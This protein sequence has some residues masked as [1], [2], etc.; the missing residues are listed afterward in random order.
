MTSVLDL[1]KVNS[2]ISDLRG[3]LHAMDTRLVRVV[4]RIES[5]A[6][7]FVSAEEAS[8]TACSSEAVPLCNC[9]GVLGRVNWAISLAPIL[10][11]CPG[12]GACCQAFRSEFSRQFPELT[13]PH[14]TSVGAGEQQSS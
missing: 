3:D 9:S 13:A 11:A 14:R 7:L 6:S 10:A 8:K 12:K 4:Q 1:H 2:E 5:L